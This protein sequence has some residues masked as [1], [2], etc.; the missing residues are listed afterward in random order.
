VVTVHGTA[1]LT[2]YAYAVVAYDVAGG[3]TQIG[4]SSSISG[5]ASLSGTNYNVITTPVVSGG[6]S[7]DV[8]RTTG[9]GTVGKIGN[10]SCGAVLNDTGIMGNGSS[11]PATNS[12]G[13]MNLAGNL[14]AV[15][16]TAN[17]FY[18]S[19]TGTT[20]GTDILNA[21]S[22]SLAACGTPVV[23]P[24]ILGT[25]E[26]FFQGP[27]PPVSPSWGIIMPSA[28]PGTGLEGAL[29]I[30]PGSG[31]SFQV[32]TAS[33]STLT[34]STGNPPELATAVGP[35]TGGD[36][37]FISKS[38]GNVD[39]EDSNLSITSQTPNYVLAGPS[40]GSSGTA[41]FRSLVPA[42]MP[43]V[44]FVSTTYGTVA[45]AFPSANTIKLVGTETLAMVNTSTLTFYLATADTNTGHHYDIGLYSGTPGTTATLVVHLASGSTGVNL[46]STANSITNLTW[47]T[48]NTLIPP[49]RYYI[50]LTTDC[51]S[52]CA[53]I[54]GGPS[55][56][57]TQFSFDS[58]ASTGTSASGVLPSGVSAPT[59]PSDSWTAPVIPAIVI[60]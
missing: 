41:T 22:S 25:G 12:T 34:D 50:A 44:P 2:T 35:F 13:S 24:C 1:G 16:V 27:A 36:L 47:A 46:N 5:Y 52:S 38:S 53:T 56:S 9:G 32:S 33:V 20:A 59:L 57:G 11:G 45:V 42:D 10:V 60:R 40:S 51:S 54:G 6:A 19:N 23:Q 7:C 58:T 48:A 30:S 43:V 49:G 55:G 29:L 39:I 21:G 37:A 31:S 14:Q 3:T 8:Y 17:A 15:G 18:A 28:A 4:P 26:F